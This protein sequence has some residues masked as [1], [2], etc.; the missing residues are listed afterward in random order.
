[1]CRFMNGLNLFEKSRMTD[2]A[3]RWNTYLPG[4]VPRLSHPR[5][6]RACSTGKLSAG[7]TA[8]T[9]TTLLGWGFLHVFSCTK[10]DSQCFFKLTKGALRAGKLRVLG[11]RDSWAFALSMR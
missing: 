6:L 1:M 10:Q 4:A 9:S 11:A 5:S 3:V 7:I 2:L 8:M